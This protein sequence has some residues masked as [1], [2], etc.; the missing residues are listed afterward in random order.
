MPPR[1]N[2]VTENPG[3][4]QGGHWGPFK[5]SGGDFYTLFHLAGF[6]PRM[7]KATDPLNDTWVRQ[8]SG[9]EGSVSLPG[10][11]FVHQSGA[12][13]LVVTIDIADGYP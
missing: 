13:L 4:S 7:Y 10:G 6:F 3:L 2:I 8:D 1:N 12:E 11:A 5:S 9:G